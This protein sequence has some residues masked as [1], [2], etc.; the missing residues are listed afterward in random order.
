MAE[1]WA[2][3]PM[4]AERG[5]RLICGTLISVVERA[6]GRAEYN[7][8]VAC[9]FVE[10]GVDGADCSQG[11]TATTAVARCGSHPWGIYSL[12][13]SSARTRKRRHRTEYAERTQYLCGVATAVIS[14]R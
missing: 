4:V 12:T 6:Y 13:V 3:L 1:L 5:S 7:V 9:S 14:L 2:L 10:R 8:G 11:A